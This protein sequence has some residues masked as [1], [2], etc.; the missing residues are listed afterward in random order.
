[1]TR[2]SFVQNVLSPIWCGGSAICC[3][4]FDARQ[5]W[6]MIQHLSPTWYLA[7]TPMQSIIL[8]KASHAPEALRSSRIRLVCNA[9]PWLS[10]TLERQLRDTFQCEV[11]PTPETAE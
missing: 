6:D 8:N 3:P 1:M 11:L 10:S 4:G 2:G 9:G 5:F 7:S